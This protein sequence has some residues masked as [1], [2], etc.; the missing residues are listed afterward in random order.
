MQCSVQKNKKFS[1]GSSLC[2]TK[3]N[4]YEMLKSEMVYNVSKT[5]INQYMLLTDEFVNSL[6]YQWFNF[7]FYFIGK[8]TEGWVKNIMQKMEDLKLKFSS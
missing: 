1:K 7:Y 2:R 4:L 6:T 8:K 5:V 3:V